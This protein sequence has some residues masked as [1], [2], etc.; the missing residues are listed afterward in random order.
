ML[1]STKRLI[2]IGAAGAG[3]L[4][5]P[6]AGAEQPIVASIQQGKP[7]IDIRT[8]YETVDDRNCAACVGQDASAL[9]IRAR[10][11]YETG[12]WNDFSVLFEFDQVFV[13]DG[14]AYN[15]TRNGQTGLP[16]IAD[17]EMTRLNRLQLTYATAFD[18]KITLGRQ[19]LILGNQRFVGNVGWR[20][21]EQT[22]DGVSAVNTSL[23]DL[24]VTYAY[25]DRVNRAFGDDDPVPAAGPAGNFDSSSHILDAV[26][27]GLANF[28]IEAYGLLLD[29][30]QSGPAPLAASRL[31]TA[32]YG[33]RAEGQFKVS[34]ELTLQVNAEYAH[35]SDYADNPLDVDLG[36]WAL[37]A[38]ATY[39][40]LTAL[41][42][43][44]TLEGD[45]AIGFSTPLATLHAFNGWAD[46]FL[47]TPPNGLSDL[48]LKAAYSRPD[49]AGMKSVS[50]AVIYHD[51]EADLTGASLGS[52]WDLLAEVA[53]DKNFSLIAKF[54]AYEGDGNGNAAGG[55]TPSAQDKT[56]SWVSATFKY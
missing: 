12:Y 56:V 26:Y 53:I 1:N 3:L 47:T 54:A 55:W 33:L 20:Q 8:R 49:V 32:T 23:A 36:Y 46:L 52:E 24:T 7:I 45:G 51:F 28:R 19:R 17:P 43:Y 35:Q 31:S 6:V 50:V 38:S 15:D 2:W 40:G 11:G 41:I 4:A 9:T 44:E 37:E 10:L 48:Y 13:A 22:F 29:L 25:I 16:V 18:T 30:A 21:H 14:D 34:D 39:Q 42:G 5:A 27:V